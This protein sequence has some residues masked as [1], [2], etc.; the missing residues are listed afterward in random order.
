M[1]TK[2]T[3]TLMVRLARQDSLPCQRVTLSANKGIALITALLIVAISTTITVSL[4]HQQT[5][6]IQRSKNLFNADQ[7]YLYA[8]G[9]ETWA[10]LIL[11]QDKQGSHT[12]HLQENWA[13]QLPP[14]LVHG[15]QLSG[16]LEDMQAR[17]NLNNLQAVA[18]SESDQ[19]TEDQNQQ[20]KNQQT[21]FKQLQQL[22]QYLDLPP[23]WAGQ[24]QDWIDADQ[25]VS[26][27]DGAEDDHYARMQP[28]YRSAD[29]AYRSVEELRLL[30]DMDNQQYT[31]L[32]AYVCALPTHTTINLNTAS[33]GVLHSMFPQISVRQAQDLYQTIQAKPLESVEALLKLPLFKQKP[34]P[35]S[36]LGVSSQ[37]FQLHTQADIDGSPLYLRS[38]LFR[39]TNQVQV[40][41]RREGWF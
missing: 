27:P 38:L 35:L 22:L 25:Q 40:L 33:Q 7:A 32:A 17:F 13:L 4:I 23:V 24:I 20:H 14:T 39:Q 41:Q 34:P 9:A 28:A 31:Q 16:K 36:G 6:N 30:I 3:K 2:Q 26:L 10:K 8:L 15:G 21:A 29:T 12:D 37:Y 5:L 18:A 19:Q 11:I 1:I